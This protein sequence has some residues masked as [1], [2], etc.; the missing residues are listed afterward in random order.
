MS[1]IISISETLLLQLAPWARSSRKHAGESGIPLAGDLQ[2]VVETA[3]VLFPHRWRSS[4]TAEQ[5]LQR[6]SLSC[7]HMDLTRLNRF[8]VVEQASVT[9]S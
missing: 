6:I 9:S 7:R 5:S 2:L 3:P 4:K 1:E 8:G